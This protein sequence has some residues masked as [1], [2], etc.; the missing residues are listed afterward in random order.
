MSA[1]GRK[2]HCGSR[3][4]CTFEP[5]EAPGRDNRQG[6]KWQKIVVGGDGLEPPT[7]SV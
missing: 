6:K 3:Y 1:L 5:P 2:E 4:G 7:L